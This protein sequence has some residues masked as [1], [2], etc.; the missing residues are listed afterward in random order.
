MMTAEKHKWEIIVIGGGPAGLTAA[1]YGG[2]AGHSV[3]VLEQMRFGGE[4]TSTDWVENYPGFPEGI[5]GVAYAELLEQQARKFGALLQFDILE[6]VDFQDHTKKVWATEGEFEASQII[7]AT[8]TEPRKLGV[9]GEEEFQGRGIS[10]CATCDAGF[11]RDKEVAVIGGGDVAVEEA[12]FMTRFARKVYLIHRRNRLRAAQSLQDKLFSQEGIEIFWDTEL[13]EIKG[14]KKLGSLMLKHKEEGL[15]ELPVSGAFM[16]V[17]RRPQTQLFA[18]QIE[19]DQNGFIVT[20][21]N[22][23]TSLNGVLAAGDVRQ[24]LL[25]QLVTAAADGAIAA[26]VAS[27]ELQDF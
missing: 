11:F 27:R 3:L 23:C 2:R 26:H 18:D 5:G 7:I 19:L 10:Y 17:G 4:I 9:Q 20:D 13:Q 12:L 24:K 14:E 8:G 25:R 1:I 16:A 15:F 6:K 21:E 22:M